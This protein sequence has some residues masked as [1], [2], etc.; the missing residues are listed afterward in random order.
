MKVLKSTLGN[1][2]ND[3]EKNEKNQTMRA[4]ERML[5]M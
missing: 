3:V 4:L 2:L 5:V 1:M